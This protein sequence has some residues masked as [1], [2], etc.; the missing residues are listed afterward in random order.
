MSLP[1][2]RLAAELRLR[3]PEPD[4]DGLILHAGKTVSYLRRLASKGNLE[5][6]GLRAQADELERA[7]QS[8][9]PIARR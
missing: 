4:L 3:P 8:A 7:I 9:V 6:D 2:R 1:A 5:G